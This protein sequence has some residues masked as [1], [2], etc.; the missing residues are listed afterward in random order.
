MIG[1]DIIEQ[2]KLRNILLPR[3]LLFS[4]KKL[5]LVLIGGTYRGENWLLVQK[6]FRLNF[7]YNVFPVYRLTFE[8]SVSALFDTGLINRNEIR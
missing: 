4:N 1:C 6:V 7:N 8:L 5:Y 2:T 3:R